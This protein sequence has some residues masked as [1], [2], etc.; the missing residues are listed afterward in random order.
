M[1][2]TIA[3]KLTLFA[4][5]LS[6]V[7]GTTAARAAAPPAR[8][9][10]QLQRAGQFSAR[11]DCKRAIPLY[12]KAYEGLQDPV[13]LFNRAEC[14]RDVKRLQEALQDYQGFLSA[15]PAAPNRALVQERITEIQ[16]QLGGPA[17]VPVAPP[18]APAVAPEPK[19][20]FVDAP[21][22]PPAQER[23]P[24]AAASDDSGLAAPAFSDPVVEQPID[25][26]APVAFA[27]LRSDAAPEP[28][29]KSSLWPWVALGAAVIAAG[30]VLGVVLSSGADTKIPDTALGNYKF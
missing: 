21:D 28:Q 3:I 6:F 24:V 18:D 12:T 14:L 15:V 4:L 30:V 27:D 10:A 7:G 26:D 20:E 11:G 22:L 13:I 9:R 2:P 5:A 29:T 16:G 25:F 23:A 8:A 19:I 1:K 17:A